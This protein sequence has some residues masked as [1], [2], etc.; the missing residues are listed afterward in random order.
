MALLS[1]LPTPVR[2]SAAESWFERWFVPEIPGPSVLAEHVLTTGCGDWRVDDLRSPRVV[3]V[4]AG[5]QRL[6]RGDPDRMP[7]AWFPLLARGQV[8][9]PARFLPVLGQRFASVT[10]WR[11][12]VLVQWRPGLPHPRPGSAYTLRALGPADQAEL[13]GAHPALHWIWETWGSPAALTRS[14]AAR[15]AFLGADLVALACTYLRGRHHEDVAVATAPDHRRRGLAAALAAQLA[16]EIRGRGRDATWTAPT[17]NSASLAVAAA[18]GFQP[19]RTETAY[20]LGALAGDAR[21]TEEVVS[22]GLRATST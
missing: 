15:G 22:Q 2:P 4:R 19:Q 12:R 10:P 16:S 21:N 14:G 6:L 1:R 11:R 5:G 13:A 18:L 9:V 3:L 17:S 20:W 7:E 8:S